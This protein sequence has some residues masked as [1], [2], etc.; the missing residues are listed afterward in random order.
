MD[1]ET[2]RYRGTQLFPGPEGYTEQAH[3]YCPGREGAGSFT[4]DA[5]ARNDKHFPG[6]GAKAAL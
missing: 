1:V 5:E 4:R 6:E 2:V 3:L